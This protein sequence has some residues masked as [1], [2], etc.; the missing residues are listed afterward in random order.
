M[1]RIGRRTSSTPNIWFDAAALGTLGSLNDF[2]GD[3]QGEVCTP[4][5]AAKYNGL[6]HV[7]RPTVTFQIM[8]LDYV[9]EAPTLGAHARS[10][11]RIEAGQLVLLAFRPPVPGD[12]RVLARQSDDP[13]VKGAVQ[14]SVPVVVASKTGDSIASSGNLAM[15]PYG[16]GE[17]VLRRS[18][19]AKAEIIS[20]Y[21]GGAVTRNQA[22]I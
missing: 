6:T 9:P 3:E 10:W 11:A 5:Y 14:S 13:R 19:G 20:H 12:L 4:E 8:P 17:I 7:L 2:K 15:V 21:F 22:P 18:L 1:N 16:G